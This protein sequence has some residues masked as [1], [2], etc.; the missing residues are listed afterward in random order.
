MAVWKRAS[1]AGAVSLT[2]EQL[3]AVPLFV[4]WIPSLSESLLTVALPW[5]EIN[6][7][8][9]DVSLAS[10][11]QI[12]IVAGDALAPLKLN[13]T[14][15]DGPLISTSVVCVSVVKMISS[16]SRTLLALSSTNPRWDR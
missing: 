9:A 7:P 10:W 1:I 15:E 14:G 8:R 5:S 3:K 11:A 16:P 12:F 2:Q 13:C 4:S 6:S